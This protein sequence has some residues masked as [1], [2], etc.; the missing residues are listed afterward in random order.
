M[1]ISALYFP[2]LFIPLASAAELTLEAK[3][4]SVSHSLKAIA[5]PESAIPLKLDTKS[6]PA[7]E[8][9]SLVDHGTKV[10]K[11]DPLAVFNS[12]GIDQKLADLKQAI[13]AGELSLAQAELDLA[14]SEKTTPEQLKRIE[15]QAEVAAEELEYFTKTRREAEVQTADYGLKRQRQLLASYEEELKQLLKMY[16]ADDITEDTEEIILKKQKDNVA[17]AVFLVEMEILD[18][19][20]KISVSL[21]REELALTEK[22]DD[23]A[24]QSSKAKQDLPRALELKKI[25]F[26]KLKTTVFNLYKGLKNIRSTTIY[27]LKFRLL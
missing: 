16:E 22:R 13:A 5:L 18:H 6:L 10:K 24:L 12:E 7:L 27:L 11:G 1:K 2:L 3:P 20:R 19:K 9:V 8:I 23:S 21:P 4:F 25:E 15:Q 17:Y 14:T 26:A